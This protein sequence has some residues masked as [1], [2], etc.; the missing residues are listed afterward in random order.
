MKILVVMLMML[1]FPALALAQTHGASNSSELR[2]LDFLAGEWEGDGWI[3]FGPGERHT[4]RQKESI[5]S[6]AGGHVLLIEGLGKGKL[7]STGEEGVVHNA[8]AVVSYDKEAK[9]FRFLAWRA[10]GDSVDADVIVAEKSLV[11]GF[12]DPRAGQIRFTI[13]LDSAGRWVEIGETSRDG[14]T[15]RKFFE[16]TLQKVR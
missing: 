15:W 11:W 7:Q 8:F 3:E 2:K 13:K 12:R 10:T 6:K 14:Q 4:F 9:R 5:Q 16:M 1:L